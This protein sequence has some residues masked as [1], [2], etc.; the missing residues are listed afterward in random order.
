MKKL[1]EIY[2]KVYQHLPFIVC[3]LLLLLF[4]LVRLLFYSD[5][6]DMYFEIAA[7][8]DLLNGNFKTASNLDNFPMLVQQW[9]YAIILTIAD[10]FGLLGRILCVFIQNAILYI[11]SYIFIMY[12]TH[13]KKRAILC[14]FI[15]LVL[16]FNYLIS[17]RPQIITMILI[18]I[19]ILLLEKYKE[20]KQNKYLLLIIPT[21]ILAANM[22]Q[23]I[24]LYHI[25]IIAPY[26][27]DMTKKFYVDFKL[28]FFTIPYILCSLCTPYGID[29]ALFIFKVF[30]SNIYDKISIAE[31]SGG[32]I[33][34]IT[35]I[36][37]ILIVGYI[38]Y[39]IYKHESNMFVNF[40]TFSIFLL[41]IWALRNMSI[42][43]LALMFICT[44]SIKPLNQK[45]IYII[46]IVYLLFLLRGFRFSNILTDNYLAKTE[47]YDTVENIITDKNSKIYN[48][49]L[50]IGGYLEY[51]DYKKVAQDIRVE[52][53]TKE[54]SGKDNIIKNDLIM[55][56]LIDTDK[57]ELVSNELVFDI[58]NDY[59]YVINKPIYLSNKVL[60]DSDWKLIYEDEYWV[61]WENS[62]M[63]EN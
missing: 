51:K 39:K 47:H 52:C 30:K 35:F 32:E 3:M 46:I 31:L 25:F 20:T 43:Y 48:T 26:Y 23:A 21:L 49:E 54:I 14:P 36:P 58:I 15:C 57:K 63:E 60:Q 10:K 56:L 6:T 1:N 29:G 59:D 34:D 16:S 44:L 50:M 13:N 62:N 9:G 38:I 37:I 27:I 8:R 22:H 61:I 11:L 7:G 28:G 42:F 17:I 24:F 12:K 4:Y 18:M 55:K 53:F 41:S 5:N 19:E 33:F 40:Y 2:N 45:T